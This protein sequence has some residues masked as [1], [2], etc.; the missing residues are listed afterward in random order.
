MAAN[1]T[2]QSLIGYNS[3]VSERIWLIL[4]LCAYLQNKNNV[5]PKLLP[6]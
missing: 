3:A 5:I 2:A 1:M 4:K 6:S